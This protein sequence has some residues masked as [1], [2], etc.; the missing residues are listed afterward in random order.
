MAEPVV[1]LTTQEEVLAFLDTQSETLWRD[2]YTVGGKGLYKHLDPAETTW[3]PENID[4]AVK[5]LGY[6][7]RVVAFFYDEEEYEYEIGRYRYAA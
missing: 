1:T 3:R 7:T 6:N 5:E 4:G 2:D